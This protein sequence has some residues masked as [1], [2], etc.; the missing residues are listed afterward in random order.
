MHELDWPWT[1]HHYL[2]IKYRSGH[3]YTAYVYDHLAAR[4]LIHGDGSILRAPETASAPSAS[5]EI[6]WYL[7]TFLE[8]AGSISK[9]RWIEE[10]SVENG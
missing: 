9:Y 1:L 6:V 5:A 8:Y 10:K 2:F 4:M 3:D 7:L